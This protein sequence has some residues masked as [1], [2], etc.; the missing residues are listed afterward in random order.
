MTVITNH[1]QVVKYINYKLTTGHEQ[2]L[3]AYK[4]AKYNP[5][6]DYN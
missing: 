4:I 6:R 1:E 2:I 5:G 3:K